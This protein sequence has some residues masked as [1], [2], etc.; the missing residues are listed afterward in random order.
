[1]SGK[2]QIASLKKKRPKWSVLLKEELG[3]SV[4]WFRDGHAADFTFAS[5]SETSQTL[6][7]LQQV[8]LY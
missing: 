3:V 2:A 7:G 4:A 5:A 6:R 8:Y 1:M